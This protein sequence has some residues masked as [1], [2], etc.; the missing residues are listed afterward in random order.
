MATY[1]IIMQDQT[2]YPD[3]ILRGCNSYCKAYCMHSTGSP[4]HEL[5]LTLQLSNIRFESGSVTG[6]N[7]MQL[8][9]YKAYRHWVQLHLSCIVSIK[10]RFCII[11]NLGAVK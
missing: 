3:D 1:A 7:E 10:L 5:S 2:R 8:K 9:A 4:Q 11:A 6:D